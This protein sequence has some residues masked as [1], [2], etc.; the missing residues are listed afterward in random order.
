MFRSADFCITE[1][2]DRKNIVP[3]CGANNKTH[4]VFYQIYRLE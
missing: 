1:R 2:L 3:S 4:T